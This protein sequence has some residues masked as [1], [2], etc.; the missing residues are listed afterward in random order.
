MFAT[1]GE[2]FDVKKT[3]HVKDNFAPFDASKFM[4]N[5]LEKYNIKPENKQIGEG[6]YQQKNQIIKEHQ[7]TLLQQI[8][9]NHQ[10]NRPNR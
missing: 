7:G 3:H 9:K 6:R 10:G 4:P 1:S 2:G 5:H 8:I